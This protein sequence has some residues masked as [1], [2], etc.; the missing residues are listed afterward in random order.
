[1][2]NRSPRHLIDRSSSNRYPSGT[3]VS[4]RSARR[5]T[6]NHETASIDSEICWI[7]GPVA[8]VTGFSKTET[9]P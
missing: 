9:E 1:M 2:S 8:R 4:A 6:V 3:G 7:R 5:S